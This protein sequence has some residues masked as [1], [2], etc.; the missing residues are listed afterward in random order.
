MDEGI[1]YSSE[2]LILK[3]KGCELYDEENNEFLYVKDCTLRLKHSLISLSK[4]ESKWKKPF[5]SENKKTYEETVDYIKFMTITQNVD[6]NVYLL[7]TAN[8]IQLVNQYISDTMTATTIRKSDDDVKHR[9]KNIFTSEVIYYW[10]SEF[11]LPPE[12]QKW[13]LN[14]L[15]TLIRVCSEKK[16]AANKKP[17][18]A[19]IA[20]RNRALNAS[21]RKRLNSRG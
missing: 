9:K 3:I 2:E 16:S 10:M 11:N 13:H 15:M 19:E 7:L 14:R 20:K 12:Y 17:N 6:P 4:W 18:K 1:N 21:R 8:H 5:L